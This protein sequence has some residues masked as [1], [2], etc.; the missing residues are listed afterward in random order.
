M[1]IECPLTAELQPLV[2]PQASQPSR[3][4]AVRNVISQVMRSGPAT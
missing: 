2:L 3:E 1:D 4:P